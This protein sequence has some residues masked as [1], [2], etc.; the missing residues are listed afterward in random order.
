MPAS[1]R[2][3]LSL[4]GRLLSEVAFV[5]PQLRIGRMRENDVV[6]NNLA[7]S[8]FHAVLRREG[9]GFA[10]ED[11]GSEN[12]TQVNGT[13]I[14]GSVPVK[15]GDVIQ[16]GKY[17]LRLTLEGSGKLAA[18]P[19]AKP[20]DAWDA[21]QTFLALDPPAAPAKPAAAASPPSRPAI[22][23]SPLAA[24]PA[25]PPAQ[26]EPML[27][28]APGE[29]EEELALPLVDA[30]EL[31]PA[32]PESARDAEPDPQGAFAFGEEDVLPAADEEALHPGEAIP[33]SDEAHK[34]LEHTALF[35]FALPVEGAS[36]AEAVP[37]SAGAA[38]S[39]PAPAA[40]TAD[41]KLYAGVIVQ[42]D[43]KLHLLR[44]W[45]ADE[46]C[47][48]RAPECELALADAGVSRH[49]ALFTRS[50][51]RY[52]VRD[53]D[54][55]NG[56]YVNGQRTKQHDLTVGDIVRIESFEL[57][58]VLDHAPIGSE[59]STPLPAPAKPAELGRAT[60]FS[61]EAPAREQGEEL[62]L[63]PVASDP[64]APGTAPPVFEQA[65]DGFEVLPPDEDPLAAEA[66]TA[67]RALDLPEADLV[68]GAS[69][70]EDEEK[71]PSHVRAAPKALQLLLSV[72]PAQ[73][74][75]RA[76]EAL[77]LLEEE[78]V[79][80]SARLSFVRAR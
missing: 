45:D 1:P 56:I 12:G 23:P 70:D 76:R 71:E 52:S 6:V 16:L 61:L 42:R 8:R 22:A 78:G 43:G 5:G 4:K 51:D 73:L 17:E 59:V 39:A 49:H 79:E 30:L 27:S 66:H 69:D 50:A 54:S 55:V 15:P 2:V 31:A 57:T 19:K 60:Q 44:A 38:Q 9:E 14:Q 21:S 18:P 35:D 29:G 62:E 77:A 32:A 40:S 3:Q 68:A 24:K 20:S 67:E 25:S 37:A 41:E 80:L 28:L 58:F 53:L 63:E 10:L 34:G 33:P 26:P 13:R 47:A 46:L 74:S 75:P 64:T 36:P 65:T 72:D 48:G 7:V 11:L